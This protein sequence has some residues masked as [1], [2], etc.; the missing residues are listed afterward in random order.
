MK[1][2]HSALTMLLKAYRAIFKSAYVKGMASAVVL[3]AGLAAGAANA[4]NW[5]NATDNQITVSSSLSI[6]NSSTMTEGVTSVTVTNGGAVTVAASSDAAIVHE[7][8]ELNIVSGGSYTVSGGA[9]NATVENWDSITVSHGTV[10]IGGSNSSGATLGTVAGGTGLIT[11][12]GTGANA[13]KVVLSTASEAATLGTSDESVILMTGNSEIEFTG[14]NSGSVVGKSFTLDA[15]LTT[16]SNTAPSI[17]V[18]D[19]A[20]ANFAVGNFTMNGGYIQNSGSLTIGDTATARILIN[21]GTIANA[22]DGST[23]TF[24]GAVTIASGADVVNNNSGSIV[25]EQDSTVDS[26]LFTSG[27][28]WK[29][30]TEGVKIGDG[31]TLTV[32]SNAAIN[33]VTVGF[34]ETDGSVDVVSTDVNSATVAMD[35]AIL[36]DKFAGGKIGLKVKDLTVSGSAGVFNIGDSTVNSGGTITVLESISMTTHQS[37]ADIPTKTIYVGEGSTNVSVLNLGEADSTVS[38]SLNGID[39]VVSGSAAGTGVFVLGGNWTGADVTLNSGAFSVEGGSFTGD[40]LTITAGASGASVAEGASAVFN[41]VDASK[42]LTI[43]GTLTVVGG[44]DK[45]ATTDPVAAAVETVNLKSSTAGTISIGETGNLI[46]A[47]AKDVLQLK[48]TENTFSAGSGYAAVSN[49]GTLTLRKMGDVL[50]SNT[51]LN[52]AQLTSLENVLQ[53]N[54][55]TGKIDIGT[56]SIDFG[57]LSA[58]TNPE[59]EVNYAAVDYAAGFVNTQTQNMKINVTATDNTTGVEGNWASFNTSADLT[60]FNLAGSATLYGDDKGNLAVKHTTN[61]GD[62]VMGFNFKDDYSLTLEGDG[63]IGAVTTNTAGEGTVVVNSNLQVTAA[64]GSDRADIGEEDTEVGGVVVTAG[65]SLTAKDIYTTELDVTNATLDAVDIT[66][67]QSTS[68]EAVKSVINGGSVSADS[69][70]LLSGS[71]VNTNDLQIIGGAVVSVDSLTAEDATNTIYVGQDADADAGIASSTGSLYVGTLTLN[72][73]TLEIDPE[74]SNKTAIAA[75][76]DF[77]DG[78]ADGLFEIGKNATLGVGFDSLAEFETEALSKF[79]NAAGALD[80]GNIGSLI[81]LNK[82]ITMGADAGIAMNADGTPGTVVDG[83]YPYGDPAEPKSIVLGANTALVLSRD[84]F[85]GGSAIT[86]DGSSSADTIAM[87]VNSKVI[88]D[89]IFVEDDNGDMQL[90]KAG[91]SNGTNIVLMDGEETAGSSASV[92]IQVGNGVITG[93]EISAVSLSANGTQAVTFEINEDKLNALNASSVAKQLVRDVFEDYTADEIDT[94]DGL[95]FVYYAGTG[96][97]QDGS[98]IDAASNLA[99]F[100]GAAQATLMASQSTTDIIS[101]RMGVGNVNSAMMYADNTNGAGIWFAPIYRNHDSDSFDANGVDYGADIDLAGAA[102][103]ADFTADNGLRFGAMFNIGTGDADGQGNA[104]GVSNDFDYYALGVYA[105]MDFDQF[106]LVADLTYAQTSNDLDMNSIYGKLTADTDVSALSFGITGQYEFNT[107]VLDI[108]PH[109]GVRFT[110]LDMDSYSVKAGGATI[111]ST[112]A[113]TMNIVSM[114]VGVTFAKEFAA[115]SWFVKPALDLNVTF[116][117]GDTELDTTTSFDS[118]SM[119]S[120]SAEVLDDVTYGV[121]LGVS[122][123]YNALSMGLGVNYVGSDNADEFGV[124]A[125]VRYTF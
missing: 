98:A 14:T 19:G 1:Q 84:A 30:S 3:T 109:V 25:F 117:T 125:N 81:Y 68:S 28:L 96:Y 94:H 53:Q 50:G 15:G 82:P 41:T 74:Y 42:T 21:D 18:T 89:G 112:D 4:D 100:G 33:L 104:D 101:A 122:A 16:T 121:G 71:G 124:N 113:D 61:S 105:G 57:D 54:T 40:T 76:G 27:K 59:G 64:N 86:M 46:V 69:I 102:F 106:S 35:A 110:Q 29:A 118:L 92:E 55:S 119:G 32:D 31:K 39:L 88:L 52:E 44:D 120:V 43:D 9:S 37:A 20:N 51:T 47:D 10:T 99:V 73:A 49:N 11:L 91:S 7:D 66:L 77:A 72:G 2:T 116:N 115:G 13:A 95:G 90:F 62:E 23:I 26:S 8:V 5:P 22:D 6:D 123:K 114:P 79:T 48:L 93:G 24:K 58:Q 70:I 108:L 78:T 36:N 97:G 34:V 87:D 12:N 80:Q 103:G 60:S 45:P 38:G 67:G 65:N 107:S 63:K 17:D 85:T 56:I 75:V 83:E 111:A